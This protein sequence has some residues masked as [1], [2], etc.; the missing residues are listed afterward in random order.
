MEL[1]ILQMNKACRVFGAGAWL[2]CSALVAWAAQ[3]NSEQVRM[4]PARST[5]TMGG[6][7]TRPERKASPLF[8]AKTFPQPP[9]QHSAWLPPTSELPT[10]FLTA[11]ALLFE[12]GLADPRGCSY[13]E[14][15]VGT[16]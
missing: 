12:Q 13:Q 3:T 14:I 4:L 8:T 1:D 6:I 5:L 11:T 16:G 10:N 15:E 9:E 7:V 2:T